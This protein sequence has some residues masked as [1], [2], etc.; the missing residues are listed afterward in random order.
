M[1]ARRSAQKTVENLF[2]SVSILVDQPFRVG[3]IIRVDSIEGTV[4][5]IGLR[6]TRMRTVDRTLVVIPNGK[7][8]D[9]RIETL[10]ARDR[11]RFA[12]KLQLARTSSSAE[13][14]KVI[15][16]ARA[17]LEAHERVVGADVFV[18]MTGVTDTSVD[19]DVAAPIETL[20]P[21]EFAATRE[22]LLL[23]LVDVV[24]KAG[25]RLAEPRR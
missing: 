18:R 14:A 24:G 4:E 8:A 19:I 25:A 21:A 12:T 20:D 16:L 11:I 9:M 1:T 10:G 2:G 6:S 17:C 13:I 22:Q 23:G 7:L 3:A 15:E 5:S